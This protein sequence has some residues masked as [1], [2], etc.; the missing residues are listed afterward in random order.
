MW[1]ECYID[2][3]LI[4]K[5]SNAA[6]EVN[7]ASTYKEENMLFTA[8]ADGEG[9]VNYIDIADTKYILGV[10]AIAKA[11]NANGAYFVYGD[12]KATAGTSFVQNVTKVSTPAANVYTA[13]DGTQINAPVYYSINVD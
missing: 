1:A 2:G 9:G 3:V 11:A 5:L 6:S 8:E 10:R 4:F 12:F 7:G 13:A